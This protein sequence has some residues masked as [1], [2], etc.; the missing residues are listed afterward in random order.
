[1]LHCVHQ[2][3]CNIV[4]LLLQW[5]IELRWTAESGND[6]LLGRH[7]VFHCWYKNTNFSTFKYVK[8]F[9]LGDDMFKEVVI[10]YCI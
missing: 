2:V 3:I 4:S 9:Q 1:M 10:Q 8:Y 7:D 5:I 6:S